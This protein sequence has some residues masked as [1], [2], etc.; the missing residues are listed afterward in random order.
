MRLVLKLPIIS[1]MYASIALWAGDGVN[2]C[3]K[4]GRRDMGA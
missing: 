2:S 3:I 4:K 1:S